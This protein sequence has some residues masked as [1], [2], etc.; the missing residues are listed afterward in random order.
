MVRRLRRP[1]LIVLAC[2]ALPA[3]SSYAQSAIGREFLV[4][5]YLPR[6]QG[7]QAVAYLSGGIVA[8]AWTRLQQPPVPDA[9]ASTI[10]ISLRVFR[11]G[12]VALGDEVV[13]S[14]AD[15][16]GADFS[17]LCPVSSERI[18]VTW[19]EIVR[20]EVFRDHIFGRYFDSN[21]DGLGERF[22]L[23]EPS[24]GTREVPTV[25]AAGGGRCLVIWG[26][27]NFQDQSYGYRGQLLGPGGEFV[28]SNF[29]LLAGLRDRPGILSLAQA[30]PGTLA[31]VRDQG[32]ADGTD[33]EVFGSLIS[34]IGASLSPEFRVNRFRRGIQALSDVAGNDHGF[35][36]VW[37][38][39]GQDGS[40][41]GIY[42]QRFSP[43][44]VRL[45][46]EFLVNTV[47]FSAQRDPAVAMD[48]AGNFVVVWQS[49]VPDDAFS[50]WEIRGQLYRADGTPR[51][52]EFAVNTHRPN[53]Q[54]NPAV[55][56]GPNGTFTVAWESF[57][58][59]DQLFNEW[60][61]F[62]QSF[63]AAVGPEPC[64]VRQGRF[65][66]DVGGTGGDPEIN[67]SLAPR[68]GDIELLGDLDGDGRDDPCAAR[69]GRFRCDL[70]HRGY[71]AEVGIDLGGLWQDGDE[72]LLG[73]IDG[74]GRDDPCLKRD[75]LWSCDTGHNGGEAEARFRFG[76]ATAKGLLG[77]VDGDGRDEPC[78]FWGGAFRC[79]TGHDGG[80]A[81]LRIR[82]GQALDQRLL[83]DLDGDGRDDPCVDRAGNLLCDTAHDG[84]EAEAVLSLNSP[85]GR[86]LV[87]NLDGL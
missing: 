4:N 73:D 22:V 47:T 85:G 16:S 26:N 34:D 58:Q 2:L 71:P 68:S 50:L 28:G 25:V 18:L 27:P 41:D 70:D 9:P 23:D 66:C 81:E 33:F 83:G 10:G 57:G 1:W 77:D 56:C 54:T 8:V 74:D 40:S 42:A 48:A 6:F 13:V 12:G 5:A 49:F 82:F 60:D 21:L 75:E 14:L 79:D 31:L 64:V 65:L 84:G 15:L 29:D 11:P 61:I 38:S 55:A 30:A 36:V 53:E 63:A 20:E 59:T 72:P 62:A 24:P 44:G 43:N 86:V 35:V 32:N 17:A 45:G 19:S 52:G 78:V 7:N 37:Q 87:G 3:R 76:P 80:I 67:L 51:G 46:P 39:E 69:F